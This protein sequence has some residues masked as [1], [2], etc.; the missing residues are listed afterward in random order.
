MEL[1][2]NYMAKKK[3][4]DLMCWWTVPQHW[5]VSVCLEKGLSLC[6][7]PC[8]YNTVSI[9]QELAKDRWKERPVLGAG[10]LTKQRCP[11]ACWRYCDHTLYHPSCNTIENQAG[12]THPKW[13][14]WS[15]CSQKDFQLATGECLCL[16]NAYPLEQRATGP[17]SHSGP[18]SQW[19]HHDP[20]IH[21][22][23]L[24]LC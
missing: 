8:V 6:L 19:W 12:K 14:I 22:L 20:F 23:C 11:F 18:F 15:L 24:L 16:G 9:S 10:M 17:T 1:I 3:G 13:D 2:I 4:N 21:T 5:L 7:K